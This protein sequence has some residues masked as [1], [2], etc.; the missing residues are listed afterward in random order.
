M[1]NKINNDGIIFA[2]Q[3]LVLRYAQQT[4][5]DFLAALW[6]DPDVTRYVGGPRNTEA[7]KKE[8][9]QTARN[10]AKEK[11]DLW[12]VALNETGEP[13]GNAGVLPK[14]LKAKIFWK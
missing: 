9:A 5:V 6:S 11:Y 2:T 10:P 13:V 4:D 3:R 8:F 1:A 14:K 12:V 7:L